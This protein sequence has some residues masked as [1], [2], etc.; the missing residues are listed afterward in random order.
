MIFRGVLYCV[1][2]FDRGIFYFRTLQP[3]TAT[4]INSVAGHYAIKKAVHKRDIAIY[5]KDKE[6]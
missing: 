5:R 6:Q 4:Q 2:I 3:L 1:D